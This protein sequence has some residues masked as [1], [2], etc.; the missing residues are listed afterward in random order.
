[1]ANKKTRLRAIESLEKQK[2]IHE[3]KIHNEKLKNSPRLELIDYWEKEI[4]RFEQK[5]KKIKRA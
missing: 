5:I 4:E 1:M 3:E 2:K